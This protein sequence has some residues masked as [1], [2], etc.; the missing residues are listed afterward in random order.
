M[1]Q[2][3]EKVVFEL[4]VTRIAD[5]FD[6]VKAFCVE[7]WNSKKVK[8]ACLCCSLVL[9]A[10]IFLMGANKK[11]E[12]PVTHW[13]SYAYENFLQYIEIKENGNSITIK[14]Y[15]ENNRDSDSLDCEKISFDKINEDI[16]S[17]FR[18]YDIP[19][20]AVFYKE[21][22]MSEKP[23]YVCFEKNEVCMLMTKVYYLS[24][25][26]DYFSQQLNLGIY[27]EAQEK[28]FSDLASINESALPIL[29]YHNATGVQEFLNENSQKINSAL[30]NLGPY[31]ENFL[32]CWFLTK[33]KTDRA[34]A[35]I[36]WQKKF[37]DLIID[38]S[39]SKYYADNSSY[40]ESTEQYEDY[41]YST[42]QDYYSNNFTRE[43]KL[44]SPRMNGDDVKNLQERL[45]ELGFT[46][47][48][49][50]DGWFGPKTEK[51]VK[52]FQS[53]NGIPSTGIVDERTFYMLF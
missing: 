4:D 29:K 37:I 17:L 1:E 35:N 12:K 21:K 15:S 16:K 3:E 33:E 39:E 52:N 24:N 25:F 6:T 45:W 11:N 30:S 46:E 10:G 32:T 49:E 5:T 38:N 19:K 47:V 23:E 42:Q 18:G 7:K 2:Q 14:Y 41:N 26:K 9:V 13:Y 53:N 27:S 36:D 43:L 28:A 22:T 8:I 40:N 51:A 20:N 34:L 31:D 48:G 50:A 44:A